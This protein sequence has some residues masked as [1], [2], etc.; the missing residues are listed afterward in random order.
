LPLI[1]PDN[2]VEQ[3][4]RLFARALEAVAADDGAVAAAGMDRARILDDAV[5][6]LCCTARKYYD[7]FAIETA[8]HD[9]FH[10]LRQCRNRDLLFFINF[11]C[12]LVFQMQRPPIG[13][14]PSPIALVLM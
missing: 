10:A 14:P 11:L 12:I 2:L 5:L 3:F 13:T 6:A 1:N 7:A 4:K 9:V 8:L